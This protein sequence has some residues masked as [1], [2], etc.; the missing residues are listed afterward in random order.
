MPD[1]SRLGRVARLQEELAATNAF[2]ADLEALGKPQPNPAE[3]ICGET[4]DHDIDY[5]DSPE[6]PWTCRRC[7]AEI[8][9]EEN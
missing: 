5:E 2:L 8:W 7:D 6:G 4:Y 3:E 1:L 9:P